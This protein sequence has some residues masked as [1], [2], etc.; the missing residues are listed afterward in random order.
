MKQIKSLRICCKWC[1]KEEPN[2]LCPGI[3]TA[4]PQGYNTAEEPGFKSTHPE[5]Q[6]SPMQY[7]LHDHII[8]TVLQVVKELTSSL[9]NKAITRM[10]GSDARDSPSRD[11][12]RPYE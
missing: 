11:F 3:H 8:P 1:Q 10:L 7:Q 6:K 5:F 4:V 9:S 12:T 2:I